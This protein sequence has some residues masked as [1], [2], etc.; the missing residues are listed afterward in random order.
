MRY[1]MRFWSYLTPIIYPMSQVPPKLRWAIYLNPMASVIE[2][3]KWGLLGVGQFPVLPLLSSLA[4]IL[5]VGAAGVWYF[6]RSEAA[7][8]DSL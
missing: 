6:S 4:V 1:F 2:T 7:S 5:V 3:F 8:V